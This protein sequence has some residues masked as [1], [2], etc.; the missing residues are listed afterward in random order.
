[1]MRLNNAMKKSTLFIGLC[2]NLLAALVSIFLCSRGFNHLGGAV[3]YLEKRKQFPDGV[4]SWVMADM[5]SCVKLF[6]LLF[7]VF[8]IVFLFNS[9]FLL[10]ILRS[11]KP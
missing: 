6:A 5:S 10:Q 1:M 3:L 11:K 4:D 7:G 9:Y 8:L 2:I